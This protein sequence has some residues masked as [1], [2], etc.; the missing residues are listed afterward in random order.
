[1]GRHSNPSPLGPDDPIFNDG[2]TIYT[3]KS[4]RSSTTSTKKSPSK[5]ATPSGA[6]SKAARTTA[7]RPSKAE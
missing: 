6:V 5:Q 7:R 4:D 1:M 3:R 2:L